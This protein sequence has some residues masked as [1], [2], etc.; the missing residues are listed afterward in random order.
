MQTCRKSR[1][2]RRRLNKRTFSRRFNTVMGLNRQTKRNKLP[3]AGS[4]LIF[5]RDI[6]H[7]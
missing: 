1:L 6:A 2:Y 5:A 3:I 4:A 7:Q